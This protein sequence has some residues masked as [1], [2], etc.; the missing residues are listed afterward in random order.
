MVHKCAIYF[1]KGNFKIDPAL[2]TFMFE[3]EKELNKKWIVVIRR[4][5]FVPTKQYR[6]CI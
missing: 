2:A 6:L 3:E 4:K 1:C 5:E